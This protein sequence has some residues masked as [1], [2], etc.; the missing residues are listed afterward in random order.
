MGSLDGGA[1]FIWLCDSCVPKFKL[2]IIDKHMII[3]LDK[4]Y[5]AVHNIEG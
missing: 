3:E 5:D 4:A 2:R 1:P